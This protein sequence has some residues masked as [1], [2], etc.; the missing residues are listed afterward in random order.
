MEKVLKEGI[1]FT[2]TIT[3]ESKDTAKQWGSGNLEVFAT[4]AMVGL[5]ENTALK[6]IQEYMNEGQDTVGIEINTQHIKATKVS[7]KVTCTATITKVDGKKLFFEIKAE[8]ED[9]PI[10]NSKHIRYI[11]DT[12]KFLSRLG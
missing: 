1:S 3:V 10:G 4:P 7:K 5:M 11:I 9:A 8:D 6:C 2:Q 12:E